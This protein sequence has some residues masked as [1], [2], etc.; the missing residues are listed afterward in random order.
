MSARVFIFDDKLFGGFY[1]KI[2]VIPSS[3]LLEILHECVSRLTSLL[4][5]LN[6]E[7]LLIH[8]KSTQYYIKAKNIIE[9]LDAGDGDKF[10]IMEVENT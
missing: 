6:L 10:E 8:L 1:V 4:T 9:I 7:K 3:S 2:N 5:Q